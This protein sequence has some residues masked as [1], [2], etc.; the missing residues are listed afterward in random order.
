[1]NFS[2]LVRCSVLNWAVS[3]LSDEREFAIPG[4]GLSVGSSQAIVQ[5]GWNHGHYASKRMFAP[6]AR[7]QNGIISELVF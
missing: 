2:I 3:A 7:M 4:S 5:H 6:A 1:M